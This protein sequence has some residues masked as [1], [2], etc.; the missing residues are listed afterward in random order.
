M[1]ELR[2]PKPKAVISL[3]FGLI[4][5]GIALFFW[6]QLVYVYNLEGDQAAIVW[7]RG[8]FGKL[9]IDASTSEGKLAYNF[10]RVP[11]S[12]RLV[13]MPFNDRD[14]FVLLYAVLAIWGV[15]QLYLAYYYGRQK[16]P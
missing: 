15:V 3:I 1:G 5:A 14:L 12:R 2:N 8:G 7:K 10:G 11:A 16:A 13:T 9:W 6:W 4:L